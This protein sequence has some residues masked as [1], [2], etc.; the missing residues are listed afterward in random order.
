M[1]YNLHICTGLSACSAITHHDNHA[2]SAQPNPINK[3]M[4]THRYQN[5]AFY[6]LIG[7]G[8]LLWLINWWHARPVFIDEAN[9]ARNLF[10]RSFTG[11][12]QPLDHQQYAPPFFMVVSKLCGE[13][14][15]YGERALR[16]PAMLGGLVALCG[17]LLSVRKLELA[18]WGLLPVVLLFVNPTVLRYVGEMK[19]Y[20]LDLG[21]ASLLLAAVLYWP[22]PS[23]KWALAGAFAV[24]FSLPSVF[25]LAAVGLPALWFGERRDLAGWFLCV[26]AWLVSFALL[27]LVLLKSHLGNGYLNNFHGAYF[28]PLPSANG[29]AVGR[30]IILTIS[31]P[32]VAFGFTTFAILGGACAAILGLQSENRR[33]TATA[34]LPVLIVLAVSALGRYSLIDRLLLFTL[35][36]WWLLAAMGSAKLSERLA[37][38]NKWW[39][40]GLAAAWLVIAGGTNVVRHYVSPLKFSDSRRLVTKLEPGYQPVLHS[41]VVP[42]YDY[43]QRVHPFWRG[44]TLPAAEV[45]DIREL[46]RPGRYVL[47]YS[48]LT[49]K[50]TTRKLKGD[51]I[52]ARAQDTKWVEERRMFRAQAV[53][54]E[55]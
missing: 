16:L 2:T 25:V 30:A 46:P 51:V 34:I 21:V 54:I 41:S 49:N 5:P 20:C 52:W 10:D 8:L 3:L 28:F 13:L 45:T 15:G 4:T 24:W 47:L 44:Q 43:Y 11:F 37:L 50:S 35:P 14:F 9:V 6:C 18:W 39:P 33:L 22:R 55:F 29:F 12:F 23:W 53:Y 48:V 42:A 17:L 31:L 36:G 38:K 7:A 1:S 27:Y 32:K 19:P 40:L 26:V